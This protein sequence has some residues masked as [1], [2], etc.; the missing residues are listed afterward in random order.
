MRR[1]QFLPGKNLGALGDGGAVTTS[2]PV[3]ARTVRALANYGSEQKYVH[4][5]K[6]VNSRLDEVQA[7]VL[8]VKLPRLDADTHTAALWLRG[9][10][11]RWSGGAS[12]YGSTSPPRRTTCSIFSRS[13]RPVATNCNATC[14]SEHLHAGALPHPAPPSGSLCRRVRT[15]QPARDRAAAPRGTESAH[16]ASAHRE[17]GVPHGAGTERVALRLR[18]LARF[19]PH[20]QRPVHV[21]QPGP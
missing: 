18:A 16:V 8:D 3:L 6:G 12:A 17:R 14:W 2:D 10:W 5:Y 15:P 9:C 4:Q 19:F 1:L 7:A 13:L 21:P 11:P 20:R